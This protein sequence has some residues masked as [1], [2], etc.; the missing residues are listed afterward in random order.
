MTD[1]TFTVS[2]ELTASQIIRNCPSTIDESE[3]AKL[4]QEAHAIIAEVQAHFVRY[5]IRIPN[6]DEC[7]FE[8]VS[9]E[10]SDDECAFTLA[11]LVD[12]VRRTVLGFWSVNENAAGAE[13]NWV[14]E[15]LTRIDDALYARYL[16]LC[17][18]IQGT[19]YA[20]SLDDHP[21]LTH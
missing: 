10:A 17:D 12:A 19:N 9:R 15:Q 5:R 14:E 8:I 7:D 21:S 11:D 18:R 13:A 2:I 20:E 1:L 4:A 6:D 3:A 16:R